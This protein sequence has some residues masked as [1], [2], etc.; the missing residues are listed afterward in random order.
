[1]FAVTRRRFLIQSGMVLGGCTFAKAPPLSIIDTHTH[2]YDPTRPEGVPWP[3]KDSK[4]LYRKVEPAEFI[5]LAKPL[6]IV[7]TVVVEA[8]PWVNDNQYLLDLAEKE[9]FLLAIVGRLVA[10]N[11]DF[12]QNL[13]RFTK[14]PK[15]VGMRI[16]ESELV[17]A[18]KKD[19]ILDDLK[20]LADTGRTLDINGGPTLLPYVSQ[21]AEQLPNLRIVINHLANVKIDGK[22]PPKEW[23][24][25]LGRA[26]ANKN[27]WCKLSALV[28]GTGKNDGTACSKR[29]GLL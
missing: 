3:S 24:A 11:R 4:T 7:G 14:N 25:N 9:P 21:L 23:L 18:L 22:A 5:K 10:G 15:W 20:R 16:N 6:G 12:A 19:A 2:F 1:M 13:Q 17:K 28:E 26:C 27:V 8:S 29:K